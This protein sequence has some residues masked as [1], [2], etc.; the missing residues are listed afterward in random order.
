MGRAT[1]APK[2]ASKSPRAPRRPRPAPPASRLRVL[3]RIPA[4]ITLG[5]APGESDPSGDQC[6]TRLGS[7]RA[8]HT[9]P[10]SAGFRTN[11]NPPQTSGEITHTNL[12]S[13]RFRRSPRLSSNIYI[14]WPS[15][16]RSG[17]LWRLALSWP[18]SSPAS[19]PSN[20]SIGACRRWGGRRRPTSRCPL[21][22]LHC[23]LGGGLFILVWGRGTVR[24]LAAV[25]G[26][27]GRSR[28]SPTEGT[29][30]GRTL[31]RRRGRN[32]RGRTRSPRRLLRV[33]PGATRP[34][35]RPRRW[36]RRSSTR[37]QT[38]TVPPRKPARTG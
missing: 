33:H 34:P 17:A 22:C 28:R 18:V 5:R 19:S 6:P 38:R 29:H 3:Q 25:H 37:I 13:F 15:R 35:P 36:T 23:S 20:H 27:W 16:A 26:A 24:V 7:L 8:P 21:P 2:G 4:G 11:P 32:R 31:R 30:R 9:L 10:S 12:S 1:T 14:S